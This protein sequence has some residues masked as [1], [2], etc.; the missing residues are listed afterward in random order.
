MAKPIPGSRI[1]NALHDKETIVMAVNARIVPGVVKG[2]FRAA[3]ELDAAVIFELAKSEC[4]LQGGYTG[5]TPADFSKK[6]QEIAD[7]VDFDIWALHADHIGIKKG[8]EGEFA[9]VEELVK[10]QIDSGFT[11]FAIDASHIFNHEGKTI[12]EELE[13]NINATAKLAKF[14]EEHKTGEDFGLEVEVGEI[15]KKDESGMVLTSPEEAVTFITALNERGVF[16]QV[17]AIANGSTHG[18]VYDEDG[19]LIEQVSIDI[20]RTI[21]VAKALE[22]NNLKVRVAQHGITGTPR[23][24][25]KEKFPK[26]II[27]KGNVGTFWMNLVWDIFKEH[28]PGLYK[29]IWDW[30]IKNYSDGKKKDTEV[31]GKSSK[32]AIKEFFDR[33]NSVKEETVDAIEKKSYEEA[34]VFFDAFNAKGSAAVVRDF[35]KE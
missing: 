6:V 7:E 29:D 15:G 10:A 20:P 22:D 35:S 21:A 25:I 5:L 2:I 4:N 33:I 34:L 13:G 8:D 18:N 24:L 19:N 32:Y 9:G 30:T 3:K 17:I 31:F 14:I 26:G 27:I 11:S 16:P 12:F 28:E 23:D 1:F